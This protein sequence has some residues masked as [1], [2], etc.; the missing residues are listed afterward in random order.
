MSAKADSKE[1]YAESKGYS[2]SEQGWKGISDSKGSAPRDDDEEVIA[3][4]YKD[5]GMQGAEEI[6]EDTPI[7]NVTDIQLSPS[8]ACP[9]SSPLE[10]RMKFELDRDAVAAYCDPILG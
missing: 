6:D 1:N 7:V 2:K 8:G 5:D 3:S 9:I 10:L 4:D